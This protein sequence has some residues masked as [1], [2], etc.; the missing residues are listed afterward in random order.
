VH[1]GARAIIVVGCLAMAGCSIFGKK[2]PDAAEQPPPAVA[3]TAPANA[4]TGPFS[5]TANPKGPLPGASGI[6][7]GRVI[8]GYDRRP[9][10]TVI[11]I[12]PEGEKSE[13]SKTLEPVE[14]DSQGYFI[15][16]GLN[17]GQKYELIARTKPGDVKMSGR[18]WAFPPNPRV[19][20]S[21]SEEFAGA[22]AAPAGGK[23]SNSNNG[24]SLDSPGSRAS[25][26]AG[27]QGGQAELGRPVGLADNVQT[28]GARDNP[29]ANLA[30]I[31]NIP[32]SINNGPRGPPGS[33]VAARVPSCVM[34]GRTLDNF[35]L[36]DL[37]GEPW[38]YR[39][40]RGKLVLLDF[41]AT[42]CTHCVP[43][44]A[45]LK[46]LHQAYAKDGLEIV[47]IAYENPASPQDQARLVSRTRDRFGIPYQLL[48]GGGDNCPVRTQ[49]NVTAYPAL[50]LLDE[51]GR[52]IRRLD[53]RLTEQQVRDL[54][55]LIRECLKGSTSVR[56]PSS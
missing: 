21:I 17:P 23:K 16:Q 42:W 9:P 22:E 27:Q 38:E 35:A 15:I 20:I 18:T 12:V 24:A 29:G 26:I 8:D 13:S 54:D 6:L 44:I 32:L 52:T 53:G 51:N 37:T 36:Y 2:K 19:L 31:N 5:T 40:H 28:G 33:A 56:R 3:A 50:V 48:M 34:T 4:K 7:A 10:P 11:T 43:G 55:Q 46:S 14:T 1:R 49:F 30:R 41:W 47:G 39:N 25:S 45:N